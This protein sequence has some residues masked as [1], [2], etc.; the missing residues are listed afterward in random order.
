MTATR[1]MPTAPGRSP[2]QDLLVTYLDNKRKQQL[3]LPSQPQKRRSE[4]QQGSPTA[5]QK[6]VKELMPFFVEEQ[7]KLLAPRSPEEQHEP[8]GHRGRP[9]IVSR[10]AA[11]SSSRGPEESVEPKMVRTKG[12]V[13]ETFREG[14]RFRSTYYNAWEALTPLQLEEQLTK[15]HGYKHRWDLK[16]AASYKSKMLTFAERIVPLTRSKPTPQD[17]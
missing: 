5:K 3:A 14:K 6:A 9:R 2:G 15:Y 11:A 12:K 16:N 1:Q 10:S 17:S 4:E 8:K 13:Q 7:K